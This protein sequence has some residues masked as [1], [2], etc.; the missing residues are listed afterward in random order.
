[1]H[2]DRGTGVTVPPYSCQPV[3]EITAFLRK[4]R[5]H[6][7]DKPIFYSAFESAISKESAAN[8]EGAAKDVS[9]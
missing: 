3:R 1:M 8:F 2:P 6:V 9:G 5:H 7:I 4:A